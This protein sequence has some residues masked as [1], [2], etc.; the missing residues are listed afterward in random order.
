M[1]AL[2]P[3]GAD[4]GSERTPPYMGD[5]WQKHASYDVEEVVIGV[6][7]ICFL[8]LLISTHLR[9]NIFLYICCPQIKAENLKMTGRYTTW[10]GWV[11]TA[12]ETRGSHRSTWRGRK[13]CPNC[14]ECISCCACPDLLKCCHCCCWVWYCG[15]FSHQMLLMLICFKFLLLTNIFCLY[16]QPMMSSTLTNERKKSKPLRLKN[17]RKTFSPG[18]WLRRERV[19]V[20]VIPLADP[21]GMWPRQQITNQLQH[22]LL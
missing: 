19:L 8:L 9:F 11:S 6:A 21:R 16:L 14:F 10:N 22:Q 15:F 13:A 1:T 12:T 20:L 7:V 17:I 2:K 5:V 4:G 18:N 3:R